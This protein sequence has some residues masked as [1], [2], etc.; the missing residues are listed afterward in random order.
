MHEQCM[1]ECPSTCWVT[2]ALRHVLRMRPCQLKPYDAGMLCNQ[3]ES[4]DS[5][6]RGFLKRAP[7][8]MYPA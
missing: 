8:D 7:R 1:I 4:R 3:I 2:S 6:E 5:N